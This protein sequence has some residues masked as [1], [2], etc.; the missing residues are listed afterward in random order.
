MNY[1]EKG[2]VNNEYTGDSLNRKNLQL[3]HRELI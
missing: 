1:R 3:G 2:G